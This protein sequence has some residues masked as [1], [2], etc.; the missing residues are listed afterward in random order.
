MISHWLVALLIGLIVVH[1]LLTYQVYHLSGRGS[2]PGSAGG[3]HADRTDLIDAEEG[4]V[5]CPGC[6]T[7][8]ELGYRFC[9]RCVSDLPGTSG[10][11]RDVDNP[12]GRFTR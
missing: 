11:T 3:A 4:V 9:Q 2:T 7:E 1:L 6:G 8:N 12:V 10:F 5:Q